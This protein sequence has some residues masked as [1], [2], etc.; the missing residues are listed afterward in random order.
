MS[1]ADDR[2]SF[3][4][5]QVARRFRS[6]ARL[7]ITGGDHGREGSMPS[8]AVEST[9]DVALWF[10]DRARREDSYLPAQTLQRLLYMAQGFYA[11]GF[12][13]R[14]PLPAPFVAPQLGPVERT[15]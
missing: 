4:R 13:C 3:V 7:G 9:L 6:D 14:K 10:L 8:A 12:H 15:D 5:P 11:A 2:A 1:V